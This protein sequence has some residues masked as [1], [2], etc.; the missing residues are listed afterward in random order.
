MYAIPEKDLR[1]KRAKQIVISES[2]SDD[3][4]QQPVRKRFASSPEGSTCSSKVLSEVKH[5][6]KDIKSLFQIS[7]HMKIHLAYIG[8]FTTHFNAISA[9]H[10]PSPLPPPPPQLYLQGVVSG[11]WGARHVLTV[12]T[13]GKKGWHAAVHCAGRKEL[14]LI[15]HQS[16]VWMSSLGPSFH[17]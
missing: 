5:I 11:C 16:K 14:M 4:F 12:G 13:R 1:S 2:E 17:C 6:C 15:Q 7:G 8:I 3:D 10:R 9:V